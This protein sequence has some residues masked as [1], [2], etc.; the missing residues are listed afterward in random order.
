MINILMTNLMY[1]SHFLNQQEMAK[2]LSDI[3]K[4]NGMPMFNVTVIVFKDS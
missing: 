3:K 2:W 4:E 1:G